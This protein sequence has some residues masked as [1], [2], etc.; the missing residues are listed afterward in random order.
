MSSAKKSRLKGNE[1]TLET[2]LTAIVGKDKITHNIDL[3]REYFRDQS[4][5]SETMPLFVVEP[6]STEDVRKIVLCANE[7]GVALTPVSSSEPRLRR[8]AVHA[9][10]GILVNLKEMKRII[11]VDRRNRVVMIEP[12]VTFAQLLPELESE[13]LRLLRPLCPRRT[14]SVVT[15]CLEKVPITI[16]KYHT[17]TA[18]PLACTEVIFGTGDVL[19]TGEASGPGSIEEQWERM[20]A[21]KFP[22]GPGPI[23]FLRFVQGAGGSMGIVTWA[24]IRCEVQPRIHELLVFPAHDLGKAID[25][26]YQVTRRRLGDECFILNNLNLASILGGRSRISATKGDLPPWIL[27][28][29]V[30]GYETHPE[31]RVSYQKDDILEIG[32]GLGMSPVPE[33]GGM[34]EKEILAFIEK[35]SPEPYWKAKYKGDSCDLFFLTTLDR[36]PDFVNLAHR[37]CESRSFSPSELGIYVQ[38]I[39][40]G[41]ACHCE[42]NFFYDPSDSKEAQDV[43]SLVEATSNAIM[44]E[45]GF[46]SALSHPW[47]EAAHSKDAASRDAVR[48]IKKIFDPN[49]VLVSIV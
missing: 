46:F 18:E 6:Q 31:E 7:H 28:L 9:S 39:Q 42:F 40:E 32:Q 25:F 19:R 1:M 45:G 14:K 37:I 29:G 43:E 15:S 44:S 47:A 33:L 30:A 17:D 22:S 12:G 23:D 24:T 36:V 34:G 49:N 5:E 26:V 3:L 4:A 2:E 10:G 27:L 11:R 20:K 41:R 16:P 21:Q 38:P 48:K 13:G 8:D 35:P